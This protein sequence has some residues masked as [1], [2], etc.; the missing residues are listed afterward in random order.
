MQGV[1]DGEAGVEGSQVDADGHRRWGGAA[2]GE[3]IG[4]HRLLYEDHKNDAIGMAAN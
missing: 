1:G 3:R 4:G 2:V